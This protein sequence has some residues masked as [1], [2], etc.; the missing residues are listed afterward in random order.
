MKRS[1]YVGTITAI[2]ILRI[3]F[4]LLCLSAAFRILYDYFDNQR[5]EKEYIESIV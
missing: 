1:F 5:S 2:F 4:V 3:C